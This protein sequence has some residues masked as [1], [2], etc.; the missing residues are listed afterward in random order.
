MI[1]HFKKI[2]KFDR[3]VEKDRKIDQLASKNQSSDTGS[4]SDNK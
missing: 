4:N 1:N 3:S 2:E